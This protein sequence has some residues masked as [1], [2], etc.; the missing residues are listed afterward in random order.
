MGR[1]DTL[2][3]Q[4]LANLL[5]GLALREQRPDLL[6]LFRSRLRFCL[7]P[8]E[9]DRGGD[10]ASPPASSRIVARCQRAE[11]QPRSRSQSGGS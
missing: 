6:R 5:E 4:G 3:V 2:P 11:L 10:H 9:R 8:V 1:K 7:L